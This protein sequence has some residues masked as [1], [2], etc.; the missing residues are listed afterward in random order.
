M[1]SAVATDRL[2]LT[3]DLEPQN[4]DL[5]RFGCCYI[6]NALP[7]DQLEA[8]QRRLEEQAAAELELGHAYEAPG[9]G[10][11]SVWYV[12]QDRRAGL[13]DSPKRTSHRRSF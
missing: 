10:G 6:E 12:G 5:D 4:A 3:S 9:E 2:R 11:T 13:A 8:T 1:S 7:P